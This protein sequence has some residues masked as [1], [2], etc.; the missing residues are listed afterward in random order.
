M[1]KLNRKTSNI[2]CKMTLAI[3]LALAIS[4]FFILLSTSSA[5][6]QGE[7]KELV[8]QGADHVSD[9][10]RPDDMV[11]ITVMAK[12]AGISLIGSGPNDV[13]KIDVEYK[14]IKR[15]FDRCELKEDEWFLCSYSED[16]QFT[17]FKENFIV[18]I[19]ETVTRSNPADEESREVIIDNAA[20]IV[21]A[22]S[23]GQTLAR[24][25]LIINYKVEEIACAGCITEDGCA[26]IKN[27]EVVS[28]EGIAMH[29]IPVTGECL[30]EGRT[31]ISTYIFGEEGSVD[32]CVMAEDNLGLSSTSG[33]FRVTID[34]M[35]PRVLDFGVYDISGKSLTRNN[36]V[37]INGNMNVLVKINVSEILE[38]ENL[39]ADLSE[40][41]GGSSISASRCNSDSSTTVCE[42]QG[43]TINEDMQTANLNVVITDF[44]GNSISHA[45]TFTFQKDNEPPQLQDFESV[46]D[47]FVNGHN[48]TF[49]ATIFEQ[50]SGIDKDSIAIKIRSFNILELKPDACLEEGT[51]WKCYWNALQL[52]GRGVESGD[53]ILAEFNYI[54]DVLEN[55][56]DVRRERYEFE[57]DNTKPE[58]LSLKVRPKDIDRPTIREG[59]VVLVIA[60]IT[61]EHSG[62]SKENA[63]AD[64]KAFSPSG[65]WTEAEECLEIE[66]RWVCTWEY[67]GPIDFSEVEEVPLEITDNAGNKFTTEGELGAEIPRVELIEQIVDFWRDAIS[68]NRQ[69]NNEN[70][71]IDRN[72]LWMYRDTQLIS[73]TVKP[74]RKSDSSSFVHELK[75]LQCSGK[76]DG[77]RTA[78]FDPLSIQQTF[79]LSDGAED[80][81]LILLHIPSLEQEIADQTEFFKIR[82]DGEIVQAVSEFGNIYTPNE[83]INFTFDLPLE[84]ELYESPDADALLKMTE[85][86]GLIDALNTTNSILGGVNDFGGAICSGVNTV[87]QLTAGACGTAAAIDAA[88]F[89][90]TGA[91]TQ[92]CNDIMSAMGKLW[93]G[94]ISHIGETPSPEEL[95]FRDVGFFDSSKSW[96]SI[97]FYCDLFIC[98]E[99]QSQWN[100]AIPL[101]EVVTAVPDLLSEDE[102]AAALYGVNVNELGEVIGYN[103]DAQFPWNP[104][105]NIAV[106][107][108]CAPTCL[109]GVLSTTKF[110]EKVL[111]DHN[112]CYQKALLMGYS[113]EQC[114]DI[115]D[116]AACIYGWSIPAD[117][118]DKLAQE[119]TSELLTRLVFNEV[120]GIR[121]TDDFCLTS[122]IAN[123]II[124]GLNLLEQLD[125]TISSLDQIFSFLDRQFGDDEEQIDDAAEGRESDAG[126]QTSTRGSRGGRMT[127][128]TFGGGPVP[129]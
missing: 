48:N 118:V 120:M 55:S 14:E 112:L 7:L 85:N 110:W 53:I 121:C 104:Q 67:A 2:N 119:W 113:A 17:G 106:A 16:E 73:F 47:D 107:L 79:D 24:D 44:A 36:V 78:P 91:F 21:T 59:D 96:E 86:Q 89:A 56:A 80:G 54:K 35:P 97:G 12:V 23:G 69:M 49:I 3:L 77:D 65:D 124:E 101:E 82:C 99:C 34:T 42:W 63:L 71:F 19:Y 30:Q 76:P 43:L 61:E 98:E 27:I 87:R 51:S 74:E 37:Y 4:S 40:I 41:G 52:T 50:G 25:N 70:V 115:V 22:S 94:D 62:I 109:P 13:N 105:N 9:V 8:I 20:P 32:M 10:L 92:P 108:T 103:T 88:F 93:Y 122:Q 102:N 81:K 83:Q 28:P 125:R 26:G 72:L 68:V 123:T 31:N 1:I 129:R 127:R 15:L 117:I 95:E 84:F 46:Y 33:C 18:R 5:Y 128:F 45:Q 39:V 100:A 66:E 6:A 64:M 75:I 60:D 90:G 58:L 29:S 57:Y 114:D 11:N 116:R 38:E 126:Y 111:E